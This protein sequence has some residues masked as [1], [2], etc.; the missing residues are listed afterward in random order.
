MHT[1]KAFSSM[2][3][4]HTHAVRKFV[5]ELGAQ[6]AGFCNTTHPFAMGAD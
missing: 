3:S 4:K 2:Q 5:P 6:F 1:H